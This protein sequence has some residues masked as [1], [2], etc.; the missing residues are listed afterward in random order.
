M[1]NAKFS[2]FLDRFRKKAGFVFHLDR[3][4]FNC[5]CLNNDIPSTTIQLLFQTIPWEGFLVLC[6]D[7]LALANNRLLVTQSLQIH[8]IAE[9]WK[10]F[11]EIG[12]IQ[13]DE[14]RNHTMNR[15]ILTPFFSI[16]SNLALPERICIW[17][18]EDAT[19]FSDLAP[20]FPGN[21][22]FWPFGQAS[23]NPGHAKLPLDSANLPQTRK[24]WRSF[25]PPRTINPPP[26]EIKWTIYNAKHWAKWISNPISLWI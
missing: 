6:Q 4:E 13:N 8:S 17:G 22:D 16:F 12:K 2:C 18:V 15:K 5:S 14:Y 11:T 25:A 3:L 19:F 21:Y 24:Y 20:P 26:G 7:V 1:K 9:N 10:T 23:A